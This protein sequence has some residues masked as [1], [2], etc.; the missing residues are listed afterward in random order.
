MVP[1]LNSRDMAKK[2]GTHHKHV[3]G[4]INALLSTGPN[5]GQCGWFREN[6]SDV[7][8]GNGATLSVRSFDLTR[9]GFALLVMGWTGRKRWQEPA[10]SPVVA[11]A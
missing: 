10:R 7:P 4:N 5:L 3:L 6:V 9:D 8:G 2:F 11:R 1:L